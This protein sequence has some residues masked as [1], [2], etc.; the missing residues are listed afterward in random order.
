MTHVEW[1]AVFVLFG[2]DICNWMYNISKQQLRIRAD[3]WPKERGVGDRSQGTMVILITS[4]QGEE[5]GEL[6][7]LH[8][9]VLAPAMEKDRDGRTEHSTIE[10]RLLLI[11][12]VDDTIYMFPEVVV[13]LYVDDTSI[14]G[15]GPPRWTF[16]ASPRWEISIHVHIGAPLLAHMGPYVSTCLT[17]YSGMVIILIH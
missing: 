13:T 8:C 7:Q 16:R 2:R 14:E 10:M 11:R 15:V 5:L 12:C 6:M 9:K 3:E 17:Y 1:L 4:S